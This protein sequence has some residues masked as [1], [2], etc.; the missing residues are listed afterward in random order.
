FLDP[1]GKISVR[2]VFAQV[3]KRQHCNALL[4]DRFACL[5]VKRTAPNDQ[6]RNNQ[7]QHPDNDKVENPTRS[8]LERSRPCRIQIFR[9]HYSFRGKFVNPG[10]QH[11]DRKSDRERNYDKTHCGIWNLKKRK[12]LRGELGEKPCHDSVSDRCSVNVPPLQFTEEV[13]RIH[14]PTWAL[15]ESL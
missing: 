14:P 15:S 5:P 6:H 1:V 9:P 8:A 2:F 10:E 3:F 13:A 11:C 4:S 12:D 7:Q